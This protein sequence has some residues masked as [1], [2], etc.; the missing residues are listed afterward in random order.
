MTALLTRAAQTLSVR[1]RPTGRPLEDGC[2][3]DCT[4]QYV[5]DSSNR[6]F[7]RECCYRSD[8]TVHCDDWVQIANNC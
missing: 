4:F 2:A 3:P 1:A 6:L 8:C 5:C 7:R